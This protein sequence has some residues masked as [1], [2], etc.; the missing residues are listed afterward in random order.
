[1]KNVAFAVLTAL[2]LSGNAFADFEL[3]WD[4]SSYSA[5]IGGTQT[6]DLILVETGSSNFH[7]DVLL[8]AAFTVSVA[9][10]SIARFTVGSRPAGLDTGAELGAPAS[11]FAFSWSAFFGAGVASSGAGDPRQAVIGSFEVEALSAGSTD[12]EISYA[13]VGDELIFGTD[14]S[15]ATLNAIDLNG[16]SPPAHTFTSSSFTA[17]PEPS[18][19]LALLAV[20]SC[21]ALR[22]RR[23]A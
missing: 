20:G 10:P 12:L 19:A 8:T 23:A 7:P 15:D 6:M 3:R 18:S 13:T 21:L 4:N 22:R 1:M 16:G 9:D 5:G 17:V 11:T 2:L 14:P